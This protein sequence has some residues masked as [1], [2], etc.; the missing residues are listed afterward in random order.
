MVSGLS[1]QSA[2]LLLLDE[3]GHETPPSRSF[4]EQLPIRASDLSSLKMVRR[5][6][7]EPFT[8]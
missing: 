4:L 2:K 8:S 7:A 5:I 3:S 1:D 6:I